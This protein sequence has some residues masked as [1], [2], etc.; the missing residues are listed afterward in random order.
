MS[1]PRQPC[2]WGPL[3]TDLNK[4]ES[5]CANSSR[6]NPGQSASSRLLND[7]KRVARFDRAR[8]T[9]GIDWTIAC[10]L[11]DFVWKKN[12]TTARFVGSD[13]WNRCADN[14]VEETRTR[15]ESVVVRKMVMGLEN[16]CQSFE[17]RESREIIFS[18]RG[19]CS[20][21]K[22]RG[23]KIGWNK[24]SRGFSNSW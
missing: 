8:T 7:K 12:T 21:M 17:I 2:S 10:L 9:R 4:A 11:V 18:R 6:S 20:S 24:W 5:S 15:E 1:Q 16:R 14:E 3:D 23:E 19:R 13:L 22:R